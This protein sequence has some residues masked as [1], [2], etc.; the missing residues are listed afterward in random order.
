MRPQIPEPMPIGTYTVCRSGTA[1]R[2]LERFERE[3][4]QDGDPPG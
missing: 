2:R 1:R 4:G 3:S